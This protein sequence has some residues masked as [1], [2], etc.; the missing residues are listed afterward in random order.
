MI[1]G[2]DIHLRSWAGDSSL[3]IATRAIQEFWPN[4]AFENGLTSD[5]FDSFGQIPFGELEEIFVYRDLAAADAWDADGAIASLSN[6]MVHIIVDPGWVTLVID[7]KDDLMQ[8]M[9]EAISSALCDELFP[10]VALLEAA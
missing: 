3:E 6:T 5:R 7:E 2:I 4:A 9:I 10:A 8:S 1:G